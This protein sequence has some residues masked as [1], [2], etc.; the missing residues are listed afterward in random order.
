MKNDYDIAVIGAGPIGA[1][2][3]LGL[4]RTGYRVALVD[5][6]PLKD[7]VSTDEPL[8]LR[9]FAVS[10]ASRR[11]FQQLDAW[12]AMAA[13]RVS[14]YRHM[15]VWDAHGRVEF[16]AADVA[17]AEL[18]HIVENRVIQAA[19]HQQLRESSI[20]CF[21]P[22]RLERLSLE[23]SGALLGL[24]RAGRLRARLVV[25]A[26]G[27]ASPTREMAGIDV[28]PV[29]HEQVALV[30]HIRSEKPHGETARQRFLE[31]GPL[32]LLPLADG[33]C[34]IVWSTT[35]AEAERLRGLSPE[36]FGRELTLAS[37]GVLG[38]L[39]PDTE[40]VGFP[41]CSRQ[42]E[43]YIDERLVLVGDAAHTVHPL[44]GLG[45]NLGLK[46]VA[47]LHRVLARARD[48]GH[49]SGE[50]TVLRRY[51]RARRPDN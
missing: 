35:P 20:D 32:A 24:A 36:Q 47:E 19:L 34:S 21:L 48:R 15:T 3:A 11:L 40:V 16:D 2:S 17:E 1:A 12:P 44:A 22:D 8:D 51:E 38:S 33:R 46:D 27:G 26:D 41:L 45:M 13:V 5:A 23:P 29:D 37:D 14:P 9:V 18:G 50:R 42:A 43:R 49:D 31:T 6:H 10:R 28:R 30:A 39:M 25:A 7:P 4:A